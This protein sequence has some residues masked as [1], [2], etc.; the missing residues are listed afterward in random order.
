MEGIKPSAAKR[1][2][3]SFCTA[4]VTVTMT[5]INRTASDIIQHRRREQCLD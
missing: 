1:D 5:T 3:A 4:I 2:Q